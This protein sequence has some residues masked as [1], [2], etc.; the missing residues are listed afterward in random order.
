[1]SKPRAFHQFKLFIRIYSNSVSHHWKRINLHLA[2]GSQRQ[3]VAA[4]NAYRMALT[5]ISVATDY[6]GL[7]AP[8]AGAIY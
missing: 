5:H 3:P 8:I 2:E 1:M 6:K 7:V 4:R